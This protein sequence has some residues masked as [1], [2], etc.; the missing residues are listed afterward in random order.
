[1]TGQTGSSD[2]LLREAEKL[3]VRV[4]E[5]EAVGH[6]ERKAAGQ[7]MLQGQEVLW[8]V[9]LDHDRQRRLI[10]DEIH[11]GLAQ[12]LEEAI[13]QLQDS[14]RLH[15]EGKAESAEAFSRGVALVHG[16]LTEARRLIAEL[17]SPAP[18]TMRP[19]HDR[20]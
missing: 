9:L 16:A 15:K 12:A 20:P 2:E 1:M 4:A 7:A 18:E 14:T 3:R 19:A 8:Q 5:L 11:D 17:R 13:T 10:A 6:A